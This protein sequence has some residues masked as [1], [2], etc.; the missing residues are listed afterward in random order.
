M[1]VDV[2]LTAVTAAAAVIAALLYL[3]RKALKGTEALLLG[4]VPVI[5][6]LGKVR[7]AW[8]QTRRSETNGRTEEG[9][10]A[11]R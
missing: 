6:A 1:S 8:Q 3:G 2:V 11:I 10:R 9:P 5:H 7:N 4:L